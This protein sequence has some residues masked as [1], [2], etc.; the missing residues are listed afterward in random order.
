MKR[1]LFCLVL[2]LFNCGMGPAFAQS[3]S[4]LHPRLPFAANQELKNQLPGSHPTILYHG[5]AVMT[6]A[7]H[8]YAIYYGS[9]TA[10]Q[11]S[12][13]DN[14][15]ENLGGSGAFDVNTTYY[16]AQGNYIQN[17]LAYSPATDS[18]YDNYSMGHTL[19]GNFDTELITHAISNG[20]LP[21]D[22]NGI[23]MLITSPDVKVPASTYCAY[24]Y[25]SDNIVA[26]MNIK[27]AVAPD[28]PPSL[29]SGC[30]GNVATYHDTTSPN[31]DIG[32]DSVAD[33]LMHEISE[34]VTDPD[35]TAW[36]TKHGLEVGDIC[37]F[38]YEHTIIVPNGS[39]ANHGFGTR[40]YLV[41]T[42]WENTN[43]GF[44][45]QTLATNTEN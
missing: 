1:L 11:S 9:F 4:P 6:G 12:I 45:A 28:P 32:I 43:T 25:D 38:I 17:A 19:K 27:Y 5:G 21:A 14:F 13:L 26:G 8:L 44:C 18:Y 2:F 16:D 42:I 41:Q 3:D 10:T 40:D 36:F 29:Y 34:T 35:G 37:N 31:G 39:H 30:S 23:Y 20:Y 15:F 7:N 22:A 33:S 24:H